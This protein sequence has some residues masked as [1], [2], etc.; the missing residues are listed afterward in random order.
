MI[1]TGIDNHGRRHLSVMPW[2]GYSRM[3]NEDATAIV[4]FLR[5]LKVVRYKV[6]DN[7]I[8]GEKAT[9]P[10]VHFGVYRSKR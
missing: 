3:T 2:P 1:R 4:A 7:V 5:S 9:A 8:P 6:P 10:F